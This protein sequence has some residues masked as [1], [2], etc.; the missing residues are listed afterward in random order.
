MPIKSQSTR[1]TFNETV[2]KKLAS[3]NRYLK[4]YSPTLP[5]ATLKSAAVDKLASLVSCYGIDN[6]LANESFTQHLLDN[7][8][9]NDVVIDETQ[10]I[11]FLD[12]LIN[13]DTT[14][15]INNSI[16]KRSVVD[17][18]LADFIKT[19]PSIAKI[20]NRNGWTLGHFIALSDSYQYG[21]INSLKWAKLE[22]ALRMYSSNPTLAKLTT[23]KNKNTVGHLAHKNVIIVRDYN[24]NPELKE[25]KNKSGK[26]VID[27][28]HNHIKNLDLKKREATEGRD[29]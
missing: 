13:T 26:T 20:Q 10:N 14:K 17:F 25:I 16:N 2:K 4:V 19:H 3:I 22:K 23:N 7:N 11:N 5:P 12:W 21:D 27:L 9:Y 8:F 24:K 29:K 18:S 28:Y 1:T 6:C 15:L